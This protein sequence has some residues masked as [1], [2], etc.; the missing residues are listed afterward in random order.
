MP[1]PVPTSRSLPVLTST[2]FAAGFALEA[3]ASEAHEAT[4]VGHAVLP[5]ETRVAPPDDAPPFL[6]SAGKFAIESGL[7]SDAAPT[8]GD[9][10]PLDGQP[11][12]GFS[13]IRALGDGRYLVLTDNGFGSMLNSPDAMLMF[14]ELMP[15]FDSGEVRIDRTV[16]LSDP[17]AVVPFPITTESSES[18]YLTGAD[19]DLEGIQ[20][21]GEQIFLGDEFG[22]YV[23]AVDTD[24]HLQ[25]VDET[26]V[27]GVDVQ[28]PD[29]FRLQAAD[30]DDEEP[31]ANLERSRGYEGF[32]MSPDGS[33]L[34]PTLEGALFVDGEFE[35]A[36]GA[37]FLR[38]L[39]YD[40]ASRSWTGNSFRY[41]LE[42]DAHAIGDLNF[43][44]EH[45]ALV[46]ERDWGQG[47]AQMA[48]GDGE[49]E[50]CFEEPAGFKRV[51]LIDKEGVESGGAVKKVGYIDL[52]DIADPNGVARQ[53]RRDDGRFT[54]PFV[55][56][57][58]VDRVDDTHII[59]AN[60][61]NFPFSSGRDPA[62]PDDNEF[63]LL[64]AASL[65]NA[66]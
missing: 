62:A 60:D 63:I 55:T 7:R 53:G 40:I 51:Y 20:R 39:E 38:M 43:I 1:S 13:G 9:G 2:L 65:L 46:I 57:E 15:D 25:R 30:P 35:T 44:D 45:R 12:Q 54:F 17:D 18:R 19:F 28:S 3:I 14:H 33:T 16:F 24:G 6:E 37:R 50:G 56:I 22:P 10:L 11:V 49:T 4:L 26:S 66:P 27:D 29:H 58:N 31:I 48:C 42:D 23:L 61:N 8:D 34:Y 52:L 59:V 32:G 21:A 5:A 41:P 36:D 47:D 64:E